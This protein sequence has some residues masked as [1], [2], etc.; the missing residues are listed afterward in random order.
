MPLLFIGKYYILLLLVHL[1]NETYD[2]VL[3]NIIS[4][5]ISENPKNK[6]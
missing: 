5:D 1:S 2:S 3:S 6:K 4:Q